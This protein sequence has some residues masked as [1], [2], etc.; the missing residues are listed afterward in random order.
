MPGYHGKFG[1]LHV[2]VALMT[3]RTAHVPWPVSTSRSPPGPVPDRPSLAG[4][5][6]EGP[7]PASRTASTRTGRRMGKPNSRSYAAK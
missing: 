6:A 7:P 2:P 1:A 4:P 3:A 5:P